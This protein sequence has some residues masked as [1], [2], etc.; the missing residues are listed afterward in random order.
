MLYMKKPSHD[1]EALF[2]SITENAFEFLEKSLDEFDISPKFSI[3]HFASAIELFMKARLLSEHWSLIVERVDGANIEELFSGNVRTVSPN[4]ARK[5]LKNIV[6]DPVPNEAVKIFNNIATH[7]NRA[8]HFGYHNDQANIELEK[9]VTEQCIGWRHLQKLLENN[10]NSVFIEF[11]EKISSIDK[12]MRDHQGYLDAKYKSLIPDIKTITSSGGRVKNCYSCGY[13]TAHVE[14]IE[15]DISLGACLLCSVSE[16]IIKLECPDSECTQ[17]IE[18]GNYFGPP[19]FC[20]SCGTPFESW[21]S[22][23]LD[24]GV[25][26][27]SDN[28]LDHIDIN[29]PNCPSQHHS[30]V[31]HHSQYICITCFDFSSK[32]G[33]CEWCNEGQLGG[34]PEYSYL[35]GCESCD[36]NAGWHDDD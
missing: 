35:T 26:T 6:L 4:T 29:C 24:T 17:E 21:V 18:F 9:I 23:G 22:E 3:I 28:M 34:V 27:T 12:K 13:D 1:F 16:T 11:K 19:E 10:W 36:G 25:G 8:I 31:E 14:N 32:I 30:V 5:R 20:S 2:K 15:G 33:V 7:R